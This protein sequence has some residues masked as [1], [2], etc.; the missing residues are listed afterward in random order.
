[1][2]LHVAAAFEGHWNSKESKSL[3]LLGLVIEL[4]LQ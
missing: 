4:K 3:L 1:M 2:A